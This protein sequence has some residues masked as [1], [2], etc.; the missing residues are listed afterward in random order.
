M[1]VVDEQHRFGVA[2]RDELARR[3]TAG[4]RAPHTLFMTATP[5]PRTLALTF[6]GDL[7]VTLIAGSPAGRTPVVTRLVAEDK[8]DRPATTSCASSSTR[9]A[10]PTSS[11]R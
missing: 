10:R 6:Y 3:A 4:G 1:V 11:A 9:A 8:R 2:Q 5:I 7:D